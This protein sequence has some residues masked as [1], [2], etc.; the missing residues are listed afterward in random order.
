[1]KLLSFPRITCVLSTVVHTWHMSIL[2]LASWGRTLKCTG[3]QVIPQWQKN[4]HY[5]CTK[6]GS[7]Q[8]F[9]IALFAWLIC[10]LHTSI[11]TC[12][13]RPFQCTLLWLVALVWKGMR[14]SFILIRIFKSTSKQWEDLHTVPKTQYIKAYFVIA[15]TIKLWNHQWFIIYALHSWFYTY[16]YEST[17]H[18]MFTT[19]PPHP[20]LLRK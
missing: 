3:S 12:T 6:S 9:I 1:M 4:Y 8:S 16:I 18:C 5:T 13:I 17:F 14:I 15:L 2:S 10:N 7:N 19:P 11:F 20:F